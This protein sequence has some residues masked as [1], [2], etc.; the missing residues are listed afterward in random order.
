MR[1]HYDFEVEIVI[2]DDG[3]T[4]NTWEILQELDAEYPS[5]KIYDK[6]NGGK[7]KALNYGLFIGVTTDYTL[8]IDAD[9]IV[10]DG[11]T[12]PR[13]GRWFA[14]PKIGVVAGR[15][16]AGY[17]GKGVRENARRIPVHRVRPGYRRPADR[18][19]LDERHRDRS[20]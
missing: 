1:Y 16:K 19:G 7:A 9:T 6:E 3:S 10:A 4:D 13:L 12:I 8:I 20:G 15:T 18:A 5:V 14:D 11:E 17:R 2:V